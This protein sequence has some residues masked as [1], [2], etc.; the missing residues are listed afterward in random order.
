MI[1]MHQT[2]EVDGWEERK[3]TGRGSRESTLKLCS[4]NERLDWGTNLR[5]GVKG[6]VHPVPYT[7]NKPSFQG[8]ESPGQGSN[9]TPGPPLASNSARA[10]ALGPS[11]TAPPGPGALFSGHGPAEFKSHLG[12]WVSVTRRQNPRWGL[13]TRTRSS[14][15]F[16]RA[17]SRYSPMLLFHRRIANLLQ[18]FPSSSSSTIPAARLYQDG[19]EHFSVCSLRVRPSGCCKCHLGFS[20]CAA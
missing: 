4:G 11:L 20:L 6:L 12:T 5:L 10:L 19:G 17:R 9:S 16:C 3:S 18:E 13:F 2:L 15:P 8:I 1:L 7:P 14:N